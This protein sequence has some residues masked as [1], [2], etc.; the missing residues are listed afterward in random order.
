MS[1]STDAIDTGTSAQRTAQGTQPDPVE[2]S[3]SDFDVASGPRGW[4]MIA[5]DD[6]P[7]ARVP[8]RLANHPPSDPAEESP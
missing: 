2:H 8:Y 6:H 4:T 3:C 1:T 5:E 7:D